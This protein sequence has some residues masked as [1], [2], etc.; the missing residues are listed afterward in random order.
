MATD[1]ELQLINMNAVTLVLPDEFTLSCEVLKEQPA[2]TG[3]GRACT[4]VI[5]M[6]NQLFEPGLEVWLAGVIFFCNV[7]DT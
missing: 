3:P 1:G 4:C 2:V 7:S 6:D 5:S